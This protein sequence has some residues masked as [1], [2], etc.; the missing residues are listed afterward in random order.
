MSKT[1]DTL[2]SDI[3]ALLRDK[4]GATAE[5]LESLRPVYLQYAKDSADLLIKTLSKRDKKRRDIL[6]VYASEI[7]RP[8]KRQL[9]YSSRGAPEAEIDGVTNHKFMFG[10]MLEAS[11]LA[12]AQAAGHTVEKRQHPV[13]IL[14]PTMDGTKVEL[15]GKI[16]AI[17]DGELVDVKTASPYSFSKFVNGTWVN[18]D[19]FGYVG[20]LT[21]YG[22]SLGY[23]TARL[24]VIN[25]SDAEI[26]LTKPITLDKKKHY[27][28][29]SDIISVIKTVHPPIRPYDKATNVN[30]KYCKFADHCWSSPS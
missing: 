23:E 7:G 2:V 13:S 10:D 12:L 20:Q 21:A 16:D 22:V 14:Y 18:N 25:K 17:I 8:C 1:I 29:M 5:V 4:K 3:E 11:V 30:C 24:L 27:E 9:W 19:P 15:R 28:S 26:H 6:T